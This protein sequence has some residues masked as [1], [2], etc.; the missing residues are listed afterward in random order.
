MAKKYK[1]LKSPSY[2]LGNSILNKIEERGLTKSEFG[3]LINVERQNV[4]H[5]LSRKSMD[6]ALLSKI[7]KALEHDFFKELSNELKKD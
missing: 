4:Q 2:H 6:T 3:R 5:I 7:S 1:K